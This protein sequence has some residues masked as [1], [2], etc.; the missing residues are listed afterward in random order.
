MSGNRAQNESLV[1]PGSWA[2]G[3]T[4]SSIAPPS[5]VPVTQPRPSGASAFNPLNNRKLDT[6]TPKSGASTS[7]NPTSRK[8]VIP[9]KRNP[10]W[11]SEQ[12]H[13][14]HKLNEPR[15]AIAN[16]LTGP[17]GMHSKREGKQKAIPNEII[18]LSEDEEDLG[19]LVN[20]P[21]GTQSSPDPLALHSTTLI[22]AFDNNPTRRQIGYVGDPP[23]VQK[24]RNKRRGPSDEIMIYDSDEIQ[25]FSDHPIDQSHSAGPR[26]HTQGQESGRVQEEVIRLEAKESARS[27]IPHLDL[28]LLQRRPIASNMKPKSTSVS[29][30]KANP[31]RPKPTI[32]DKFG[33]D[34]LSAPTLNPSQS[35]QKSPSQA[36]LEDSLELPLEAW[37]CGLKMYDTGLP[38]FF[39]VWNAKKCTVSVRRKG[40]QGPSTAMETIPI[41]QIENIQATNGSPITHSKLLV[42]L[43]TYKYDRK[44]KTDGHYNP[45]SQGADG[46]LTFKFNDQNAD[47]S[48]SKYQSMLTGLWKQLI[49]AGS[50]ASFLDV[51]ASD[52]LWKGVIGAHEAYNYKVNKSEPAIEKARAPN[53]A[54]S[55]TTVPAS[56]RERNLR[57][58][59]PPSEQ[60]RQ[61]TGPLPRKSP[62]VD[63]DELVLVYPPNGTGAINITQSDFRRLDE[64]EYLNDTLI[65]FGLKLWL[66][67]VRK[68]D[69]ML[70]DSI[71]VFS[72]FFYK[73]LK[74][75]SKN[76]EEGYQSVRKWTQKFDLFEKKYLVV[77]INEN[78]HWYLAI[79]YQPEHIL[80]PPALKLA[81]ESVSTRT[82]KQQ[83]GVGDLPMSPSP[84]PLPEEFAQVSTSRPHTPETAEVGEQFEASCSITDERPSAPSSASSPNHF[85]LQYP[86]SDIVMDL[87]NTRAS[88]LPDETADNAP[89]EP[90]CM[91][92]D[93]TTTDETVFGNSSTSHSSPLSSASQHTRM[94]DKPISVSP[95]VPPVTFYGSGTHKGV[96]RENIIGAR[97]PF[98]LSLDADADADV[99]VDISDDANEQNEVNELLAEPEGTESNINLT[100]RTPRTYIFTLDSLGSKHPQALKILRAYLKF[101]AVDK[102]KKQRI[103]E[104]SDAVG[105]QAHVLTQP[106]FCDC[107]LYLL[108]L[109]KT[110]M[111]KPDHL[112]MI[113][114]TKGKKNIVQRKE[115]WDDAD[116]QGS[117]SKL[118]ARILEM[119]Q[120]WKKHQAEKEE[121]K[122]KQGGDKEESS[123]SDIDIVGETVLPPKRLRPSKAKRVR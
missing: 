34:P 77:P 39:F 21:S 101:E 105:L 116:A 8:T 26:R 94:D 1:R 42:Q 78:L 23:A 57:R 2:T 112:T 3:Y 86:E 95:I 115:E 61:S 113:I 17:R 20:Q 84:V 67:D 123:D 106:N 70:A 120:E 60:T 62:L 89:V 104:C 108:H 12:T 74:S 5:Q 52:T 68:S 32:G 4:G 38:N 31:F 28:S 13:K 82:R 56:S 93:K 22:H 103:E 97:R 9:A 49:D 59:I 63:P 119:S 66:D 37:S 11:Q 114:R 36:K 100:G 54:S 81:A 83:T 19:V 47:W 14:R 85:T 44:R 122:Q 46:R 71:H 50:G 96:G 91:D 35:Q 107:G 90:A 64:G 87:E 65:E 24:L 15:R 88:E 98:P 92:V 110:F 33:E 73:K 7:G 43:S 18:S 109:T 16:T 6:L 72:S 117:R 58:R 51:H 79:I 29:Q 41:S 102:L 25:D 121:Q 53:S 118:Q 55:V 48:H 69:P 75:N 76:L 80:L 45:G 30:S 27:S 40:E 99:D 111:K 10:D